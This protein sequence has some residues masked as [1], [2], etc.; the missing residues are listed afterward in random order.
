[1]NTQSGPNFGQPQTYLLITTHRLYRALH[2]GGLHYLTGGASDRLEPS[3][4][5]SLISAGMEDPA[6]L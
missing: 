5:V 2:D 6:E 1:M 3:P 4:P